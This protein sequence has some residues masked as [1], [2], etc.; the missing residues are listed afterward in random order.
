MPKKPTDPADQT[1][2]TDDQAAEQPAAAP[3][4][5]PAVGGVY[6][7]QPDGALQAVEGPAADATKE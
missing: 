4:P 2:Q 3:E 5:Q 1:T 6:I 7:R